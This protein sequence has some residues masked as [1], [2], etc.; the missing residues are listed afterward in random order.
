M[1]VIFPLSILIL[2]PKLFFLLS[3]LKLTGLELTNEASFTP[4]PV[5]TWLVSSI[6]YVITNSV[7]SNMSCSMNIAI[8][9]LK[10][11][12]RVIDVTMKHVVS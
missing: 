12:Y 9:I 6:E 7:P 11:Q 5:S 2:F 4:C 10:V 3:H 1:A 8:Q